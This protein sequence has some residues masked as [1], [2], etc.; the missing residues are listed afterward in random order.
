MAHVRH[1]H[2]AQHSVQAGANINP[3]QVVRTTGTSVQLVLPA[4][5]KTDRPY[6][7]V[8][9]TALS[10][11]NVTVYLEDNV[12]KGVAG[13]SLGAG[14]EVLIGSTNGALVHAGSATTGDW[15]VGESETA[16][17]AGEVF[18]F[19]INPRKV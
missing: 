4:T 6:G 5:T 1:R 8:D 7:A 19:L 15:I 11:E 2:G 18:S 16:A 10:G 17:A 9:A 14:Q 13:A 12:V 3:K